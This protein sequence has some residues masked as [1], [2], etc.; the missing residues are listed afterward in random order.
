MARKQVDRRPEEKPAT[1]HPAGQDRTKP[2]AARRVADGG[3]RRKDFGKPQ[4]PIDRQLPKPGGQE[5]KDIFDQDR[6]DRE[7]GRP[8]QLEDETEPTLG[9]RDQFGGEKRPR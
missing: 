3:D 8:I 7:S 5:D 2:D 1:Q 9:E 6:S 4:A